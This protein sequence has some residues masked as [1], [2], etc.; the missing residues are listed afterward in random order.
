MVLTE[1]ITDI[2]QPVGQW[3]SQSN[4]T[5]Y[6]EGNKQAWREYPA[7][8][9]IDHLMT[10]W[11]ARLNTDLNQDFNQSEAIA[12]YADLQLT[13]VCIHPFF[14]GNGRMARLLANIP[15]LKSGFPP[16]VIPQEDQYR[17]KLC[18]SNY[19]KTMTQLGQLSDLNKL[20]NNPERT[21][22]IDLCTVY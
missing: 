13:F 3:K 9:F 7:P 1:L 17:Y 5:T 6:I 22:F 8:K 15:V 11:L 16:I 20:P 10:Q 4:F 21:Q 19:Q 12:S 18:L 2:D 14:D